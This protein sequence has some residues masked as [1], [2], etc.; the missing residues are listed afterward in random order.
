[1]MNNMEM[2]NDMDLEMAAGGSIYDYM[3]KVSQLVVSLTTGADS[4][5]CGTYGTA[6]TDCFPR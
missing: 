3:H 5:A 1:M 4:Q 6:A 2:V